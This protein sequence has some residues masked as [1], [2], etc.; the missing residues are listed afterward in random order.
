LERGVVPILV[1]GIADW[2]N[3]VEA[4][5]KS[6]RPPGVIV[7][8]TAAND[9]EWLEVLEAGAHYI[10]LDQLRTP[11]LFSLLNLLWRGWHRD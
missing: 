10:A 1:C 11:H 6:V 7:V 4:A 3:V 2:R 9:L 8:T 5:R